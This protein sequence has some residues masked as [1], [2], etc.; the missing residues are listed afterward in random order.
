MR[1][2]S[3]DGEDAAEF[4]IEQLQQQDTT[5]LQQRVHNSPLKHYGVEEAELAIQQQHKHC[6]E[7][8][9]VLATVQAR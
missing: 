4:V 9:V 6:G 5:E 1:A 2:Q 3:Q 7:E 8:E